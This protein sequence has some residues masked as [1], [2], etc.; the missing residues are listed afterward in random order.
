VSPLAVGSARLR[1]LRDQFGYLLIIAAV[2][3][4]KTTHDTLPV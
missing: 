4:H 1:V 3:Q 2:A